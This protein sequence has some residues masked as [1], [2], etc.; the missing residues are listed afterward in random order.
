[1]RTLLSLCGTRGSAS[2]ASI[3]AFEELTGERPKPVIGAVSRDPIGPSTEVAVWTSFARPSPV[4]GGSGGDPHLAAGRFRT[5]RPLERPPSPLLPQMAVTPVGTIAQGQRHHR[6]QTG[7]GGAWLQSHAL[8]TNLARLVP[9]VIY[10]YRFYPDG[11]SAFPY[12]SPGMNDI[13]EVTP[14]EVQEDATPV[15]GGCIRTTTTSWPTPSK[16]QLVPCRSST[17]SSGSSFPAK[18]CAGAGPRPTRSGRRM[19]APSGTASSRTSPSASGPR[20]R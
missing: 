8:L 14:E 6:A 7:G 3:R 9:G 17:A 19:A 16:N 12:S 13:Y 10:Q 4:I 2:L 18:V 20:T 15:S 1:M 5:H 11:R